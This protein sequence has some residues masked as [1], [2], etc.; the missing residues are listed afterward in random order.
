MHIESMDPEKYKTQEEKDQEELN[1]A[2]VA[3][4]V[5]AR[6]EAAGGRNMTQEEFDE[7]LKANP[8]DAEYLSDF[9]DYQNF[10]NGEDEELT[11]E[12][13]LPKLR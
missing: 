11:E 3:M 9:V 6:F 5:A 1:A 12:M 10:V 2:S 7:Y 4:D 13:D 8:Q